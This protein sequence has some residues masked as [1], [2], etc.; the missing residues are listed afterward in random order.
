MRRLGSAWARQRGAIFG[1]GDQISSD[2]SV[3]HM[4]QQKL[5]QAPVNNLDAER[6]VGFIQYELK[7]RGAK[8]LKTASSM[9]VI[10]KSTELTSGKVAGKNLRQMERQNILPSI[11]QSWEAR[12]EELS[13][14]GLQEK[15]IQNI[16]TERRRNSD[17]A[18]LKALGGPF[19]TSAEVKEYVASSLTEK[20]K[21]TRLYLEV[22][23]A[24]DCSISFPKN[25]DIF[26]LKKQ[27]KNLDS[28]IYCENFVIFLDKV[29]F[30]NSVVMADFDRALSELS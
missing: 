12:Q 6:S 16:A 10:G 2:L 28:Q 25:S 5:Q 4:D 8:N 9:H 19:T 21:V 13:R 15:E 22:R 30:R 3:A 29:S 14:E 24:R 27:F 18:K 7:I 1:F 23:Y 11:V 17:L 26:R 20:E